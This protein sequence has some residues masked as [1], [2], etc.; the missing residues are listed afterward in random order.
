MLLKMFSIQHYIALSKHDSL[1]NL[2]KK[3]FISTNKG[4]VII[5]IQKKLIWCSL[6]PFP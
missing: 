5:T 1:W 4:F 2:I 3:G 6:E